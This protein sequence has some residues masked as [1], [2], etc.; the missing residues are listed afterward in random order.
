MEVQRIIGI[1]RIIEKYLLHH[2]MDFKI[3][4]PTFAE[5]VLLQYCDMINDSNTTEKEKFAKFNSTD[6]WLDKFYFDTLT[7]LHP[8]LKKLIKLILTLSHGQA[9]I[10]RVFNVNKFID[11]VNMEE[12]SFIS[13]KLIIDHMKQKGLQPDTVIMKSSLIKSVKAASKRY[14]IYL[15]ERRS[16]KKEGQ[17]SKQKQILQCEID[18]LKL[19][20][21]SLQDLCKSFDE[22]FVKLVEEV[23][24]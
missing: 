22:E 4:S 10:E 12:N 24:T 15:E 5:K 9:S 1:S 20:K 18:Q 19:H 17:E 16:E 7:D 2:L 3:V 8:E 6:D 11:H 13:R 23:E 14:D 21:N